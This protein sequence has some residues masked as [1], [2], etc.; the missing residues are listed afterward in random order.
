MS[1]T[2][3]SHT[4]RTCRELAD[5]PSGPSHGLRRSFAVNL[6]LRGA[7]LVQV[8]D[9][10]GHASV[11]TTERYLALL[12]AERARATSR[13]FG[14]GSKDLPNDLRMG[15]SG[16]EAVPAPRRPNR[17]P[18]PQNDRPAAPSASCSSVSATSAGARWPRACSSRR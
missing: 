8:R 11:K 1:P 5:L 7:S 17:D 10:L 3:L 18:C 6:L 4:F 2:T 16:Y 15:T 12:P 13:L 14:K 9:E